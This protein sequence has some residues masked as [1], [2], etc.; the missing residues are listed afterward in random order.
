MHESSQH[1]APTNAGEQYDVVVVSEKNGTMYD[2]RDMDR[3]G[4]TQ[5]LNVRNI[6]RLLTLPG[7]Y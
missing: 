4:K 1:N 2:M 6:C 7:G 3:I 5:E